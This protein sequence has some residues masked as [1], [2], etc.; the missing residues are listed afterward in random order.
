MHLHILGAGGGGDLAARMLTSAGAPLY[1]MQQWRTWGRGFKRVLPLPIHFLFHL[2]QHFVF[3]LQK[4]NIKEETHLCYIHDQ[5]RHRVMNKATTHVRAPEQAGYHA[6]FSP[7]LGD[8]GQQHHYNS[9]LKDQKGGNETNWNTESF[10]SKWGKTW[11]FWTT[12]CM[13][14]G[15]L[16][17]SSVL[18]RKRERFSI[19]TLS[20]NESLV[21]NLEAS[22][23]G[24][25]LKSKLPVRDKLSHQTQIAKSPFF[26]WKWSLAQSRCQFNCGQ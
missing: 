6:S 26:F 8:F 9:P 23:E 21:T 11:N 2:H 25:C 15:N 18:S 5:A 7:E 14:P 10:R 24:T 20:R 22:T 12:M 1:L 19:I 3:Y 16:P 13:V 4:W 17:E